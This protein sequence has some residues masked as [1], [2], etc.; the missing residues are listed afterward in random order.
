M[1]GQA[2]IHACLLDDDG[3]ICGLRY[4]HAVMDE[5]GIYPGE[6]RCLD[7]PVVRVCTMQ[8]GTKSFSLNL[9]EHN[10]ITPFTHQQA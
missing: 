8:S 4:Q 3:L 1:R 5:V 6:I 9:S 10:M 2:Y 7:V